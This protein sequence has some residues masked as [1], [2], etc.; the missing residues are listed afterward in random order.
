MT[1]RTWTNE[2]LAQLWHLKER[3]SWRELA[4]QEGVHPERL[5]SVMR[6]YQDQQNLDEVAP[7]ITMSH[8][9]DNTATLASNTTRIKSL[10]QLLF[11]AAVDLDT[12]TVDHYV[13]NT[14][15][16]GAKN[17]QKDIVFTDGVMNGTVEQDGLAVE[18][19]FQIKAWLIRKD[20]I[21]AFPIVRP[22]KGESVSIPPSPPPSNTGVFRALQ[23]CDPHFGFRRHP[24]R[25]TL[26]PFHCRA[27][28][29]VVLQVAQIFNPHRIDILGDLLDLPD[30]TDRFLRSPE[31]R[32]C[33]QPAILECHFWLSLFRKTNKKAKIVAFEGNHDAR[34]WHALY[35]NMCEA[36]DLH[37]ANEYTEYPALSIP[38]LLSLNDLGIEWV[39]NY[40][41]DSAQI[42]DFRAM[43]GDTVRSS[44]GAT[45]GAIVDKSDESSVFGHAHRMELA[46]K[47]HYIGDRSYITTAFSSGCTCRID[48]TVPGK[49]SRQQ[50]QNGFSLLEYDQDGSFSITFVPV[51]NGRAVWNGNKYTAR[52]HIDGLRAAYPEWNW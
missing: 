34:I 19:L 44:P 46:S 17:I 22:V 35:K 4:K 20:P 26:D 41:H 23:F 5:R 31:V 28:L 16:V 43:H 18:T 14:W 30:F 50:W 33:T 24:R 8:T 47:T 21:F 11:A 13:V 48:G 40:P 1:D 27:T 29:D 52:D 39:G 3:M 6:R 51:M 32:Q 15:E 45:A 38:H 25:A 37:A 36:A 2:Q 7:G 42:G 10:D 12:W 9:S 49:T